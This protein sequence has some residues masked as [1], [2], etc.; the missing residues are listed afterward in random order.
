MYA[1]DSNG[2]KKWQVDTGGLLLR[3]PT[4]GRDGTIYIGAKGYVYAFTPA[5]KGK[6]EFKLKTRQTYAQTTPAIGSDGTVYVAADRGMDSVIYAIN[7]NG[8]KKWE[9]HSEGVVQSSIAIAVDGTLYA[10]TNSRVGKGGRVYALK[11]DGTKKWIYKTSEGVSAAPVIGSDG[12]LYMG[13]SNG[14]VIALTP[15]GNDLWRFEANGFIGHPLAIDGKGTLFVVGF[16][17]KTLYALSTDS[18]GPINA[19]WPMEGQN[20]QRTGQASAPKPITALKLKLLGATD[21]PFSFFFAT[22]EGITYAVEV[23]ENLLQWQKLGEIKGTLT[24]S[25]KFTDPRQPIVRFKRNYYRVKQL[26]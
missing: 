13:L 6:W 1:V 11:S 16:R 15:D 7:P 3:S 26:D 10:G 20:A 25:A 21:T 2:K 18:T 8:F 14:S 9:Y 4:V 24:G 12:S 22:K 17:G 23:S 5:G 19:P